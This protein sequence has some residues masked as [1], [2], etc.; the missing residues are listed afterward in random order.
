MRPGLLAAWLAGLLLSIAAGWLI[1]RHAA[2]AH[3]DM[4]FA[5]TLAPLVLWSL[6]P[7]V[8]WRFFARDGGHAGTP[9]LRDQR[10]AVLALLADRGLAGRRARY[11]LPFYLVIGAPG[12]GKSSLLDRSGLQLSQPTMI[13]G[14]SWWAGEEAVFVETSFGL[15]DQSPRQ[16]C[17]LLRSLRPQLP[18]NGIVLVA[19][20]A[21][22]TLSDQAEHRELA[23][24][25]AR[26]LREV[27]DATG[28]PAPV[29]LVLAKIDLLPGFLEFFDR[30]EPQ[31]RSQPWG[32]ALPFA[33]LGKRPST[34]E[35]GEAVTRGFQ[36]LLAAMRA[37]LVEWL[38]READ[39]VRCARI[40]GFGAQVAGL[41]PTIQPLLD[42]LLPGN[43]RTWQGAA[44]RGIYLTSARQ[45]ALSID[46]L[47]PEL[48]RR[49]AMPRI[50]MLP[51]DLGL[52]EEEQGF[53]IG[54]AFRNA[55]FTEAGLIGKEQG[56]RL[57]AIVQWG[58][59]AAA[60]AAS[61]GL[62]YLVTRNF[63]EQT[64]LAARSAE[65]ASG[66]APVA[67][68][69]NADALPAILASMRQLDELESDL[70]AAPRA[71]AQAIGLDARLKLDAAAD[72]ARG[73]LRRNGL[74][75]S[76]VA[77]LET[78]LVDLDA[79][80]DTLKARIALAEAGGKPNT[81]AL[82]AWLDKH[83]A[84]L[85]AD[86]RVYFVKESTELFTGNG[87]LSVDPAYV[88]AARRII[89]YKESLS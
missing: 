19:S 69:T 73:R 2:I 30:Q 87:G 66:I 47:L 68:P 58:A 32:F 41:Q 57:A 36:A 62:G 72:D 5:A 63:D 38:S 42:A 39:P 60:I 80:V 12:V 21:D 37:R 65:T 25:A 7:V 15:P 50:G 8:F 76:L 59:I 48:S 89:A 53:F 29:Y 16:V 56:P 84:T 52:D 11:S 54:G 81:A 74:A 82:K 10:R 78:E 17:D 88:A 33:G 34:A 46:G 43:G 75:P 85:P 1:W 83:A 22:L 55:V 31:E 67:N 77:M 3:P 4:R 86:D 79:D 61:I 44:L 70:A 24:G 40:N 13:G 9:G 64:R 6:V 45:E 27:E 28:R 35:A 51:P 71:Q 14:A 20:P 26:A 49:F 23:Q 18:L